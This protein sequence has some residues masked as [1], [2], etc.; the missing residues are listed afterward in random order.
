M[1]F[2]KLSLVAALAVSSAFASGDIEPVKAVSVET[3]TVASDLTISANLTIASNYVWRGMSQT[4]DSPALQGGIDLGYKGFYLGTWGSNVEFGGGSKASLEADLYVG[5]SA[6]LLGINYDIG[7]FYGAYPNDSDSNF[8][9]ASLGLSK[10]FEG[11]GIHGKYAWGLDDGP[12]YWEVGG[13][14]KLPMEFGLSAAYGDYENTGTNYI[15]SLSK[16]IGKFELKVAYTDFQA[17][18]TSDLDDEDHIVATIS[19][20]F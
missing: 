5:Y 2:I 4:S 10:A 1:K 14:V 20:S 6:E 8:K 18:T 11:F 3:P 9:E 12:D 17:D 16:E 15:I 13:S 19:T 7:Y